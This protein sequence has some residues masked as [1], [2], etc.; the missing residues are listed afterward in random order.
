MPIIIALLILPILA[1]SALVSSYRFQVAE[2][3]IEYLESAVTLFYLDTGWLPK[4]SEGLV[5]LLD[6]PVGLEN[7]SGPYLERIPND[8]WGN[9]YI[10]AS[11]STDVEDIRIYSTGRDSVDDSGRGDDIS[12]WAGYNSAI[13]RIGM[14]NIQIGLIVTVV[15]GFLLIVSIR[16]KHRRSA[17]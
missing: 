1:S 4:L 10:Y 6:A 3:E 13:Y 17:T 5:V 11:V 9:A 12:S 2:S 7:W 15:V 8:P 14:T 16:R